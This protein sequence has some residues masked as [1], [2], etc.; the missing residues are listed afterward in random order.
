MAIG[1]IATAWHKKLFSTSIA[2][3]SVHTP[4]RNTGISQNGLR[5]TGHLMT[6][7]S[8][9]GNTMT[10]IIN[11]RKKQT[12]TAIMV[13]GIYEE[14]GMMIVR[15][16]EVLFRIRIVLEEYFATDENCAT[17]RLDYMWHQI[18]EFRLN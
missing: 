6:N 4:T 3:Q 1:N 13:A 9:K 14:N 18:H 10:T 12:G 8:Y 5:I 15:K 16:T 2:I 7:D 17:Q 11:E